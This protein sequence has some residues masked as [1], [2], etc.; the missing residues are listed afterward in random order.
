M[1]KKKFETYEN[2][3]EP[4]YEFLMKE[5][6]ADFVMSY[7]EIEDILGF[8]LPRAADRAEWWDND[9]PEHPRDQAQAIHQAGYDSRRN[10]EGGKVRF[11]RIDTLPRHARPVDDE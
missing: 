6:R 10:S 3:F 1:P 7:D 2:K 9:T 11:R 4:L 8:G 5:T